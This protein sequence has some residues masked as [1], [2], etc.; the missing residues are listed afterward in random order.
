MDLAPFP[1]IPSEEPEGF[2]LEVGIPI[3]HLREVEFHYILGQLSIAEESA[4]CQ[5]TPLISIVRL[6]HGNLGRKGVVSC[7]QQSSK[8]NKILPNLPDQCKF[9]VFQRTHGDGSMKSFSARRH[10]I[11]RALEMYQHI[12]RDIPPWK[13]QIDDSQLQKWPENGNVLDVIESF[14]NKK[15]SHSPVGDED[16][17]GPAPLQNIDDPDETFVGITLRNGEDNTKQRIDDATRALEDFATTIDLQG[18]EARMEQ[19]EVLPTGSFASMSTTP[20]AWALAFPT[21][22]PPSYRNGKWEILG[23]VTA[24]PPSSFRDRKVSVNAWAKWMMW[25]SN[26]QAVNHPFF[27]LVLNSEL[28]RTSLQSQG[29]VTLARKD[30]PAGMTLEAFREQWKTPKGQQSIRNALNYGAG[31]VHGTSQYWDSVN[32]QFKAT[33]FFHEYLDQLPMRYFHTQSQAEFHDPFLRN[34]LYTYVSQVESEECAREILEDDAAFHKAVGNYKNVVT[35]FFAFKQESWVPTMLHNIYG[36]LHL[37]G[38]KEFAKGRGA[39]HEH[40]TGNSNTAVDQKMDDIL[41]MLAIQS[42]YSLQVIDEFI[43]NR[44]EPEDRLPSRDDER[45]RQTLWK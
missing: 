21:L 10:W 29:R 24:P 3:S 11:Q 40:L 25:N 8:L 43:E 44:L 1:N 15:V 5:I 13:I 34:C 30:I 12:S 14:N 20:Y 23:N 35:H 31:N 22:F 4:I 6:K 2:T 17:L 9:L 18:D 36:I 41:V 28:T 16:I 45:S 7:I 32:R 42:Y 26:G 19:K 33:A 37:N 27:A 39:I 38:V